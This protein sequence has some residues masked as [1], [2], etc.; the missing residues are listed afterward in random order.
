MSN[1][2]SV[3]LALSVVIVAEITAFGPRA[4]AQPNPF[5]EVDNWAQLPAGM[6]WG[7]VISVDGDAAGNVWVFHRGEPPLLEF[8]SSGRLLK[9]LCEG[10]FV[11]AHG[12][13]IDTDG[14]IWLTDGR[15]RGGKGHQVFKLNQEGKV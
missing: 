7:Q 5:R 4:V 12:L 8:D 11:Q 15:G 2:L 9:S 13:F 10:M 3:R 14:F 1:R 6:K